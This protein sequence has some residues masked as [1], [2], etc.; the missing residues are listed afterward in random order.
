[1]SG[2]LGYPEPVGGLRN[3]SATNLVRVTLR[4]LSKVGPAIDVAAGSGAPLVDFL[5]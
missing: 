1:V 2:A 4:D 3:G 5:S